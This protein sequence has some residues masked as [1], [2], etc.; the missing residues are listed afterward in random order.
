M[1][2]SD[3]V[4]RTEI[5]RNWGVPPDAVVVLFCA[6]L[7]P[8]KRPQDVLQAFAKDSVRGAY[9]IYVGEG[10]MRANLESEAR[11]LGIAD[12][13]RFLGFVNQSGLPSVYRSADVLVLPSEYD[14][15]GVVVNE[16][17]LCGCA[18]IVSDRVGA[19][20]DL[21]Q[22]GETGFV[23]PAGDVGALS[24]LLRQ[25]L[26]SPDR[27]KVLGTAAR[28]RMETWSPH[29]NLEAT[30]VALERA[31]LFRSRGGDAQ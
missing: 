3:G 22:E 30:I 17:M 10:P 12:R 16:A 31:V 13:V 24:A 4:D 8:W 2:Q 7:Q 21:V 11:A 18:A 15:F 23:F 28:K 9:L 19:R 27:L 14:A 5:R 29:Q 6:K 20:F 25:I 1:T 26:G